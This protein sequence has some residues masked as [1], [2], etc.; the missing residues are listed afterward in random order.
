MGD[1]VFVYVKQGDVGKDSALH[2]Q[3]TKTASRVRGVWDLSEFGTFLT[4]LKKFQAKIRILTV[5]G[6]GNPG[7]INFRGDVLTSSTIPNFTT[8][9]SF[10]E[11]FDPGAR[12]IFDGCNV[13]AEAVGQKFLEDCASAFL[14]LNGGVVSARSEVALSA[15]LF[16]VI[17]VSLDGLNSHAT[18]QKGGKKLRF[19]RG[20]IL[21]RPN[22]MWSV[23][24]EGGPYTYRFSSSY[25]RPVDEQTQFA[26]WEKGKESGPGSWKLEADVLKIDWKSGTIETWDLPLFSE[27]QTGEWTTLVASRKHEREKLWIGTRV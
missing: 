15:L 12:L 14:S 25:P 10:E 13:G 8:G 22:G 16:D 19:G 6:H 7:V 20:Q 3:A 11:L 4:D 24:A 23:A 5:W 21:E 1:S 9:K 26:N 27:R 18:I 17:A 2:N